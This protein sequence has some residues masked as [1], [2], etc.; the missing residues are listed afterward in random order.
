MKKI[1]SIV[2]IIAIAA[3][4][5]RAQKNNKALYLS[6]NQFH[7]D[8]PEF[9]EN[10]EVKI[11]LNEFL[12]RPFFTV[13]QNGQKLKVFKDEVFA[14]KSKK[15]DVIRLWNIVPYHLSEEGII[16]IYYREV[17]ASGKGIQK[18]KKY[19]YSV[20][21][22]GK[23]LPLNKWNLKSSF[24]DKKLFQNFLDAQFKSDS[25]LLLYNDYAKEFQ[26]NHLLKTT[27][28]N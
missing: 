25:E 6:Y 23:I 20:G 24:P 19:Y 3:V 4:A 13:K 16:W 2:A 5:A 7:F 11:K 9:V 1:F 14:Y 22:N 26:V 10:K 8:K 28:N 12:D 17:L 15:G 21:G 27:I 18:E